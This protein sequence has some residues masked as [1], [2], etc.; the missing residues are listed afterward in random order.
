M[1]FQSLPLLLPCIAGF[2]WLFAYTIFAPR[3]DFFRKSKRFLAVLSFFFLFAFLSSRPDG[4]MMLH[5]TLFEQVCALALVPSFLSY[6]S[7]YKGKAITSVFFTVCCMVPLVHFIMGV[8][9]VYTAGYENSVKIMIDSYS[10][11]GPLFPY[12]DDNGQCVFYA[13][14]TY[15]YRSFILMNFLLFAVNLVM[16]AVKGDCKL[17]NIFSFLFA[18]RKCQLV[19]VLYILALLFLLIIVPVQIIGKG[20]FVGN[21]LVTTVFCIILSVIISLMALI[22]SVGRIGV[23]SIGGI[24]HMVRFGSGASEADEYVIAGSYMNNKEGDEVDAVHENSE[25]APA[26]E[27]GDLSLYDRKALLLKAGDTRFEKL[28]IGEKLF[29]QRDITLA[30]VADSIGMTREELSD[31]MEATYGLSFSNY[32]NMLRIDFAEQYILDNDDAT[33]KE[34]ANACGFSGASAFNTTFSK[35]TGVT[36][37]IWKD[38]Y[39]ETLNR[40]K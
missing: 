35:I 39:A 3:N 25:P 17:V 31:Y 32:V 11:S 8:E 23:G 33:Q 22:G 36:P 1:Q 4:F 34:I 2:F 40:K 6:I 37:K 29:L 14:Y 19:P 12:L 38:R 21:T 28:L 26:D 27:S 20:F 18:G 9:S 24:L 13:C 30:S 10:T 16:C 7:A 5:Y 15:M